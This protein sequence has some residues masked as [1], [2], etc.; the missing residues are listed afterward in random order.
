MQFRSTELVN[1]TMTVLGNPG[2]RY[3]LANKNRKFGNIFLRAKGWSDIA[4][5]F[6]NPRNSDLLFGQT[7]RGSKKCENIVR[8]FS[9]V[10]SWHPDERMI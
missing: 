1:Q 7:Q 3:T 4:Y 8:K 5:K 6:L 10:L 9:L 2:N